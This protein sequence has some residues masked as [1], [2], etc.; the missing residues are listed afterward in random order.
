MNHRDVVRLLG[1]E[2]RDPDDGGAGGVGRAGGAGG[3][4]GGPV[5]V[6]HERLLRAVGPGFLAGCVRLTRPAALPVRSAEAFRAAE[7]D[8]MGN[9]EEELRGRGEDPPAALLPWARTARDGLLLWD[10]ADPDPAR[11]TTVLTDGAFRLWL[12]FPFAASEFVARSLLARAADEP[13]FETFEEYEAYGS[14]SFWRVAD[15]M[16]ETATLRA[17]PGLDPAEALLTEVRALGLPAVRAYA[18]ELLGRSREAG[19]GELPAD[20]RAVMREFPGGVVAG[21]RVYPVAADGPGAPVLRRWPDDTRRFLQ[22]GEA[23]GRPL[24]WLTDGAGDPARW[25]LASAAA[26]GAEPEPLPDP[27]FAAF[28][29]RRL[30]GGDTAAA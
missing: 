26:D 10:T 6:D 1:R 28:L 18:E 23:D 27:G 2:V 14:G 30:R 22:W 9:L 15:A 19:R 8:R 24:G 29:L 13:A 17:D 3:A 7:A 21:V 12:A 11:W 16:R 20:F 4:G 5:P 25:R